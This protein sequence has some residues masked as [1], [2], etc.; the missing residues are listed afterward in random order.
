MV[1]N[2]DSKKRIPAI[3]RFAASAGLLGFLIV[4]TWSTGRAGIA[5]F[6]AAFAA[7][8]NQIAAANSA[9]GL[10]SSNPDTH[11]VRATLLE[12]SDLPSAITEYR[13]AVAARPQDYVLWLSLARACELNNETAAAL[14]AAREAVPLAPDYA[15]PHYQLG[16]ILLRAGQRDEAFRELRQAGASNPTLLP[17]II[18]LAWRTSGGDVQFVTKAIAPETPAAYQALGQYFRQRNQAGAAIAM[19]SAAGSGAVEDRR[20]YLAEL[21]AAKQFKD[22][23]N[24]WSV[25]RQPAVVAG[26]L[27]DPGFEQESNLKDPGFGWR[28][29]EKDTGFRLSLDSVNPREGHTSLKVDFGGNSDPISPVLT[30]LVLVEPAAHYQLRFAARSENLVS[31]VLP[32]VAVNEPGTGKVLGQSETFRPT[33]SW[34]EYTIDFVAGSSVTAIQIALQR[35]PCGSPSCPIFGRLWLDSFSIRKL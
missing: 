2:Q 11:Y 29:G 23:A 7:R 18:D 3:P 31:G 35:Q 17:G 19:Y 25:D 8:S 1:S 26:V 32:F 4:L 9:V 30:Q 22:A 20:W 24:L 16:N 21:V 12:P 27:I 10:G 34:R 33:D 14:E 13:R 5:S 28:L 15:A 6:L